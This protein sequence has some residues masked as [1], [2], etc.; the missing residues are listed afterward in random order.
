[1][2]NN[3]IHHNNNMHQLNI[4][5]DNR[6]NDDAND[7]ANTN[8][9]TNTNTNDRA[10]IRPNESLKCIICLTNSRVIRF[11]PC[12][13]LICCDTCSR[14]PSLISCPTCRVRIELR[15]VTYIS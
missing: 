9:N 13:H 14:H 15:Q 6:D 3:I 7:N 1:M 12:G 8:D 10:N 2:M 5:I 4:D 11:D